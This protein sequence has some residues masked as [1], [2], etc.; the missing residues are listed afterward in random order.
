[1]KKSFLTEDSLKIIKIS[2]VCIATI[3]K[4]SVIKCTKRKKRFILRRILKRKVI[5]VRMKIGVK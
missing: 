5:R 4:M 1:M 3:Q 2:K